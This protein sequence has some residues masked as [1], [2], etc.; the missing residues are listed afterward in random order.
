MTATDALEIR[1]W[2]PS[3]AWLASLI[4]HLRGLP[5]GEAIPTGL[6]ASWRRHLREEVCRIGRARRNGQDLYPPEHVRLSG[7]AVSAGEVV[8]ELLTSPEGR[9]WIGVVVAMPALV[10]AVSRPTAEQVVDVWRRGRDEREAQGDEAEA[11]LGYLDF[12][13]GGPAYVC[14]AGHAPHPPFR[15]A[16]NAV[17]PERARIWR[18][19]LTDVSEAAAVLAEMRDVGEAVVTATSPLRIFD[20]EPGAPRGIWPDPPLPE[21]EAVTGSGAAGEVSVLA[22]RRSGS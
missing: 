17:T 13:L 5:L 21:P 9:F 11:V 14:R 3:D 12:K 1:V 7:A 15:A 10:D 4:R 8:R 20:A 19:R 16:A 2:E 22:P 18:S 6:L